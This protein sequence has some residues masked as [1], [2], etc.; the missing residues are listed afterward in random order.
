VKVSIRQVAERARVS[1]A[2]VSRVLNNV[3]V[4]ISPETRRLVHEVAAEMG[5]QPN[6][7]AKAL[8][9]GRTQTI[10]LWATNLRSSYYGDMLHY[11]HEEVMRHDYELLV[12]SLQIRSD[13][14]VDTFKLLSCP[15]D[16]VLAVD[17]PRGEI[18]GLENSFIGD[19]PFVNIGGYVI[20]SADYVQLDFKSQ[21]IEA[22][23]HLAS[24]GCK[25]IAYVVPNWFDWFEEANDGRLMGY[26]AGMEELGREPNYIITW[27]EK[28]E[29][30]A[31]PL[32]AYIDEH[33]CPDGLFFYND[34]MAIGAYPILNS[35]G[36]K[37]PEDV[38]LVGCNGIRVTKYLIPPLTNI[39]QPIEQMCEI[40]WCFLKQRIDDPTIPLQ[41]AI[42]EPKLEIRGSSQR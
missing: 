26:R 35:R 29:S 16:G 1:H 15:V 18:P 2:T 20:T 36:Y 24:V 30:L 12:S 13:A 8:V 40:A 10:A 3:N 38:A 28:L 32:E 37:I 42:L 39:I 25:R 19:L 17:L 11:M 9:T 27:D 7:A 14:R 34:D 6:R 22:V 31:R 5:Y 4:P 21:A 23:R 41:H 33:G